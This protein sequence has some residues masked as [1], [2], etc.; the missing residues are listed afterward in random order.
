MK[1]LVYGEVQD[2]E[3]EPGRQSSVVKCNTHGNAVLMRPR[4]QRERRMSRS[5]RRPPKMRV[6]CRMPK[7]QLV[8]VSQCLDIGFFLKKHTHTNTHPCVCGF[9]FSWTFILVLDQESRVQRL[10]FFVYLVGKLCVCL[11]LVL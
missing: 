10:S 9:V 6:M 4:V 8:L 11:D 1:P 2:G 3:I 7:H 5:V